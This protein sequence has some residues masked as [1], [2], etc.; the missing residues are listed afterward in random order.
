MI[1]K[2][3]R[4]AVQ[5]VTMAVLVF[6]ASVLVLDRA[7]SAGLTRLGRWAESRSEVRRTLDAL[8]DKASYDVLVLGT[9]RTFEAVHP[10][11]IE[12]ALGVKAF[13]EASKGKGLRYGYEFY[14]LYKA[15]VGR[16]KVVVYGADY[17]MFGMPSDTGALSRLRG[18]GTG[19]GEG[20]GQA[21][22]PL[23]TLAR[24]GPN[25]HAILGAL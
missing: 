2:P 11:H 7:A 17:F 3:G 15:I 18:A 22:A 16:P 24:K 12:R 9:S 20:E 13:K 23:L 8:P 5:E 14:T 19:A 25:D 21:L 6:I 4:T 1:H 10:A